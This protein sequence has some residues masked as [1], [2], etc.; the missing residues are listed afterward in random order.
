MTVFYVYLFY[1]FTIADMK[2]TFF[3]SKIWVFAFL[4]T[5]LIAGC[6]AR[7][8]Q[9][10]I[11]PPPVPEVRRLP[12]DY[13]FLLDNSGSIPRGEAREFAREAI[14]AFI[15]LC[16]INDKITL[17]T[18]DETARLVVSR[19]IGGQEDRNVIKRAAEEGL[20]FRGRY[21]DIS[22]AFLY[23]ES[24]RNTIFR[25]QNCTPAVILISDGKLEPKRPR[26]VREAYQSMM[27]AL[28]TLTAIP[29]YTIGLGETAIYEE[30]LG[31]NGLSLLR[32]MA[33]STGGRFYHVRS[34]DQ[35]IDTYFRILRLTKGISEIKGRYIFWVDESTKRIS[36]LVIK[37]KPSQDICATSDIFIEDAKGQNITHRD[38]AQFYHGQGLPTQIRWQPGR[39]YDLIIIEKPFSG[40]WK[41]GLTT[42]N[43]PEAISILKTLINLRCKAKRSYWDKEKKTALAWLYDERKRGLSDLPCG[44]TARF[45]RAKDFETSHNDIQFKKADNDVYVAQI[46]ADLPGDYLLQVRAE[47]E[48]DYFYRLTEPIPFSIKESY[49][50]F[51]FPK[52]T[53]EKWMVGWK[54]FT[55][56]TSVDTKA[57][58]YTPFQKEP[59]VFL[60]LEKIDEEGKPHTLPSQ[61]LSK[62]VEGGRLVYA[63][64]ITKIGLG[65]YSGHLSLRGILDTG[66]KVAI[67]S[68]DFSF[69]VKRP[70]WEYGAFGLIGILVFGMATWSLRPELMGSLRIVSPRAKTIP[71]KGHRGTKK[72]LKGDCLTF[73]QG[74]AELLELKQV[75]FTISGRWWKKMEINV[76]RGRIEIV[77]RRG[78]LSLGPGRS[79]LL[80]PKDKFLFTDSGKKY[81]IGIIY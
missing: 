27:S 36:T 37:R 13:V 33:A 60:Y 15:E 54:G 79:D 78:K 70:F 58:N 38:Y 25:G 72:G 31:I 66:E 45:D 51:A 57:K 14:K 67:A 41:V 55:L 65:R 1:S 80:S 11:K 28:N 10:V 44:I 30:F 61:E 68:E 32:D 62:S 34:V 22:A 50:S 75:S 3:K 5:I 40:R 49:F 7:P 26:S 6:K 47:N 59:D 12:V 74:G 16:E 18:F 9:E 19:V 48:A 43:E 52:K 71:L 23:L 2:R 20:T 77:R 17:I 21:T 63:L 4:L 42:G 39:Y 53:I 69:R 81:E 56:G 46:K 64:N 76:G 29:F 24:H 8:P 35:L 73:G